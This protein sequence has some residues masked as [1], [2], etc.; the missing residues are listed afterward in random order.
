MDAMPARESPAMKAQDMSTP[1]LAAWVGRSHTQHD[2]LAAT[3][4]RALAATLGRA[5]AFE[6]GSELPP[7]WHWLYCLPLTPAADIGPDGH[8]QRGG[9][10]PPV[11][12]P[13]RMWAGS[14]FVFHAPLRVGDAL[15]RRSVIEQVQAKTG[16]SGALVFV[17]VRHELATDGGPALTEWHDIVYREAARADTAAAAPTGLPAAAQAAPWRRTWQ[18]DEVLLFRYSALTFNGHRIHYDRRWCTEVEGYPGLVVHGPLIATLLLELLHEHAPEVR[19][20]SYRFRALAPCFD[21]EAL[22]LR[23]QPTAGGAELWATNAA[24]ALC[25]QAE[26]GFNADVRVSRG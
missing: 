5:Q 11:A 9:F 20:A 10:L 4:A 15:E 13:R 8:A 21:G 19:L 2:E 23:G 14:R 17:T 22:H 26:A 7:L 6:R 18:P 16:S 12:L 3:P 24:G 25:M 1:E